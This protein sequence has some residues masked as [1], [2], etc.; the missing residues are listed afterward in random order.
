VIQALQDKL[1]IPVSIDTRKSEV[2]EAAIQAGAQIVN[3]V[4][5]LRY[6][7]RMV[8][9]VAA[10]EVP[11]IIMHMKGTPKTMQVNP[12][13]NHL[14]KEIFCFLASRVRDITNAGIRKEMIIL[15]PGIGFGKS[16]ENNFTILSQLNWLHALRCPLL[17]GVSRKS[18][19]GRLLGVPETERIFGTA[20]AVAASI[21]RG[22]H[23]VRVHDVKEMIQVTRIIDYVLRN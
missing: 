15:D 23:L 16:W 11:V 9:V 14:M 12:H 3:D 5:G 10:A 17:I 2:A 18:F 6:D 8:S 22:V 1:T 13:Y 19:I 7:P 4:S 20:A 21:I